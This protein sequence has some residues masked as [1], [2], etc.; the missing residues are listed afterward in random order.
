LKEESAASNWTS[1]GFV[2]GNGTTAEAKQYSF[3]DNNVS[4]GN[5]SYRLK[6]IDFDGTFEYSNSVEVEISTPSVYE[7]AQNYPNPFN[8]STAIKFNIPEAG[9]VKLVVYNLLGQEVNTLV[10]EFKSAGSYTINFDATNLTS[11]VYL[12]KIEA[13]GFVQTRKMMLIK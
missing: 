2:Q 5:Y 6:Q 7:L 13:N 1:L 11:G 3:I 12:Y 8:P 10:N 9:N 4:A